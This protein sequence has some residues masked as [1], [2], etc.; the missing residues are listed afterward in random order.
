MRRSLALLVLALLFIPSLPVTESAPQ[1]ARWTIMIY[2]AGG[3]ESGINQ[4]I[5][6]DMEEIESAGYD[7]EINILLLMDG[8]AH[9]DSRLMRMSENGLVEMP[10]G[11]VNS[12]WD[13]EIDM[14]R[15][16]TLKDFVSWSLENYPATHTML[17]FWG[18][19]RGWE[20]MPAD[21]GYRVL[22]F[23][24]VSRALSSVV[25]AHG[26]LDIIGFD[27]CNMAMFEVF[28]EISDFARYGIASEKEEPLK[29]WPYDIILPHLYSMASDD[30][31]NL[32]RTIVEDYVS[33]ARNYRP[34]PNS[35]P[36]SSTMSAVNLSKMKE[37]AM[38]LGNYSS[39]LDSLL[40][41]YKLEIAMA[42]ERAES[43]D[44]EPYPYDLYNL[45][46]N[47]DRTIGFPP[48]H[49]RGRA[50]REV[51]NETVVAEAHNTS[52]G[53]MS[54]SGAH[55]ISIWFPT[56]GST[57]AYDGIE[58]V[59]ESGWNM[60][61][62]DYY[63]SV[64]G[65]KPPINAS[66]NEYDMDGDGANESFSIEAEGTG[67]ISVEVFHGDDLI[68]PVES[69]S[70]RVEFQVLPREP[71]YYL[72]LVASYDDGNISNFTCINAVSERMLRVYGTI[73]D[74]SGKPMEAR[75]IFHLQ[76]G[77]REIYA[78]NGRYSVDIKVPE[79]AEMGERV[80]V[81]VIYSTG[82][83][84]FEVWLNGTSINANFMIKQSASLIPYPV[85]LLIFALAA[86]GAL[87]IHDAEG[88]RK[89]MEKL[90]SKG[91]MRKVKR[92]KK[93]I[94]LRTFID[95]EEELAELTTALRKAEDGIGSAIFLTGEDG[96]GKRSLM[97]RFR[98]ES[99]ARFISYDSTGDEKRPYEAIIRILESINALEIASIDIESIVSRK[100]KEQ[101]FDEAFQ[102]FVEASRESPLI[103]YISNAQ[104]LDPAS[105]EFLEY[106]ARGIEETRVILVISA[107]QEELEDVGGKPHPLNAMLM[108]LMM[109]GKI[110][111]IKLERFDRDRTRA[112]LSVI[113]D[114]DIPDDILDRI[115]E[116][117]QGLPIL[118]EEIA[119]SIRNT[120]KNIYE[121]DPSEIEV[122]RSVGEIM[123]KRLEKLDE[124]ER[125]VVE[126][127][128]ILGVKFPYDVL[129]RLAGYG[130]RLSDVIYRLIEDK[131]LVEE[132]G[133]LKFDHPQLRKM[134]YEEIGERAR[135][136]HMEAA[137]VIEELH[138]DDVFSLAYHY[139]NAGEREKC[140]GY[141]MDA[142]KKAESAYSPTDAIKYYEMAEKN[143]DESALPE[144]YLSLA[145]N[146][147]KVMEIDRAI[148][149]AK[150]AAGYGGEIGDRAHL[151]LG[152][153]YMES[154]RWDEAKEEYGKA[155]ESS[156]DEIVI[157][158]YRGMG[159]VYWR[160]GEHPV[161]AE[162]LEKG[163]KL[164]E[165]TKNV[166]MLGTC[167]IDLAN[168]HSDLGNYEKAIELYQLAIKYLESVSNI[169]EISRAYNNMGEVYKYMGDLEKA[170]E[171]YK[172]CVEYAE[173]TKDITHV[174]YGVENLGT[175][176]VYMGRFEEAMEY[177]SKAY[178]IFSKTGDKYMIS[179]IYMAYGIMYGMQRK[180][181]KAEENFK[182]SIELLED[183]GIKYDLAITTYEY[184]KMLK[185][186]GDE[187]A[188]EVLERAL[189]LFAEIGSEKH[190]KSVEELLKDIGE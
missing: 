140:L 5:E 8:T 34:D 152:H 117:T 137:K 188:R 79:M 150:K 156:V 23:G 68:R 29:G 49:L 52:K 184:G 17:I 159:K 185:E 130:E 142:A 32:S 37:L 69:P 21:E 101:G 116:E 119:N 57:S 59:E 105:I 129:E 134:I 132:E 161:A 121:M 82:N 172:K 109:E 183:I 25:S 160:L 81:E 151:L 24:D 107:P 190:M 163:V 173:S 106:L 122:P 92:F 165:E 100:S 110:R 78:E 33:W 111:M 179:G 170:V 131:I 11:G 144:I 103:I 28:S 71:G 47:L 138:P 53:G 50:L 84:T 30:P 42:R 123:G 85:T 74:S 22:D 86:L 20:G 2:M 112:M 61:L 38:S 168:V 155:M 48:L 62:R 157:D 10:L 70:G 66:V 9:G 171:A 91:I 178:R 133:N 182:K 169:S 41:Y 118:I 14:S 67:T 87:Y 56:Y 13:S 3:V 167:L 162:Y 187:R 139:C 189:R 99:N 31:L 73:E 128:A 149:Y 63:V 35:Y 80:P 146:L 174:G 114:S 77:E 153:I 177:L 7:P 127:A 154:S 55:G 104:W 125:K 12:T 136:M 27:Q 126:W 166:S 94:R 164:S 181:D 96:V 97:N 18:H 102:A 113:L 19:G 88:K 1:E 40:P 72:I 65:K 120:G 176:Y 46:E 124:D 175:V 145:K 60:F 108:S 141:S 143:A 158:A 95:R 43:Y 186:K 54:V 180:W 16:E 44:K 36:L 64:P 75:V 89:R 148:E 26:R 135:D 90:K 45:T 6:R 39:V 115:Y 147:R 58:G 76:S 93:V 15:W 98:K 83:A 4:S 51:I